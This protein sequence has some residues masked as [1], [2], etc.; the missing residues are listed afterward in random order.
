MSD[1]VFVRQTQRRRT[2]EER[3][4]EWRVMTK[5]NA[6]RQTQTCDVRSTGNMG[7]S[8][9]QGF[10]LI[11]ISKSWKLVFFPDSYSCRGSTSCFHFSILVTCDIP[12]LLER[13]KWETWKKYTVKMFG[14][15]GSKMVSK[16]EILFKNPNVSITW[17]FGQHCLAMRSIPLEHVNL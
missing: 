11:L 2:G 15:F 6:I 4:P 5:N 7:P 12:V 13:M 10:F 1:T 17:L 14:S 3:K 16:P 8:L 9:P